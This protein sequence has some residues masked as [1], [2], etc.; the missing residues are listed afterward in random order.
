ML[1]SDVV[2]V[3]L[4]AY[5]LMMPELIAYQASIIYCCC[6]FDCLAWAQNN[7][8]YLTHLVQTKEFAMV[9]DPTA[10]V[11][12]GKLRDMLHANFV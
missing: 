6:N 1:L 4:K 5:P 2:G 3:L 12:Q 11:L 7:R 10:Y 9:K 8:V